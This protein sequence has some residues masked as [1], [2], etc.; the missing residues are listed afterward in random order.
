MSQPLGRWAGHTAEV[1]EIFECLEGNGPEDLLE[2]SYALA[3]DGARLAG[4]AVS[5]V[6]LERAVGSGRA[7]EAFLGWAAAQGADADWLA[8]PEWKLAPEK[9]SLRAERNGVLSRVDCRSVG[10]LLAEA[11]AG[12]S[13]GASEIDFGVSLHSIARLGDPLAAG[14]ELACLYLRRRDAG[15]EQRMAS[16]FTIADQCSAP[17]LIGERVTAS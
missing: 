2:V 11:G 17:V 3:E 10:L 4:H 14:E 15:L 6:D 16:C 7:R 1:Q 13:A 8:K 5:R 12:R 9:V